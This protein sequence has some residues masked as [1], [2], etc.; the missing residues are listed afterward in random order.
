MEFPNV[1]SLP[2]NDIGAC[3]RFYAER[4]EIRRQDLRTMLRLQDDP[5]DL[6]R[7]YADEKWQVIDP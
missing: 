6:M 3:R 5:A 2:R 1:S 4:G 7:I